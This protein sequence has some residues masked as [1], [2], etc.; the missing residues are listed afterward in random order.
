MGLTP[1]WAS[2]SPTGLDKHSSFAESTQELQFWGLG[3]CISKKLASDAVV[4]DL[5]T[6]TPLKGRDYYLYLLAQE[7]NRDPVN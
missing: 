2:A 5:E 4:E 6:P 7:G 1:E 3:W